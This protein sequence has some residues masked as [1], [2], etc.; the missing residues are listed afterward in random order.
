[1]TDTNK[2]I[3]RLVKVISEKEKLID[4]LRRKD[5]EK[6]KSLELLEKHDSSIVEY[7]LREEMASMSLEI[8]ELV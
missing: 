4:E 2:Y 3:Q 7:Q 6:E 8:K 5:K 1:M